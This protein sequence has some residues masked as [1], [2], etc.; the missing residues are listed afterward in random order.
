MFWISER[1]ADR[2]M[3]LSARPAFINQQP[4]VTHKTRAC[5]SPRAE[6]RMICVRQEFLEN[7]SGVGRGRQKNTPTHQVIRLDHSFN[8]MQGVFFS[9]GSTTQR[10]AAGDSAQP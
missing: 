10:S 1:G 9:P 3:F 2:E 7:Y 5:I 8:S 4:R 6:I